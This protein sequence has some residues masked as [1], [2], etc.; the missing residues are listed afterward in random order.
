MT[1]ITL[2]ELAFAIAHLPNCRHYFDDHIQISTPKTETSLVKTDSS[3]PDFLKFRKVI[4]YERFGHIEYR[5]A[6][7]AGQ[8]VLI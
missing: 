3:R 4:V 6:L 7:C 1:L 2:P 5:W 8:D